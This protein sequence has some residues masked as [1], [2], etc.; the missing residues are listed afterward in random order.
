MASRTKM[1]LL[2]DL[3]GLLLPLVLIFRS[4]KMLRRKE[5][6]GEKMYYGVQGRRKI[7]GHVMG[8]NVEERSEVKN[9][10]REKGETR[11]EM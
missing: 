9:A 2:L 3:S 1:N 5:G 6:G 4:V 11:T 8:H 7:E 10:V